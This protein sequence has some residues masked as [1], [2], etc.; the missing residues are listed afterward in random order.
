MLSKQ[1]LETAQTLHRI[2]LNMADRML[3]GQLRALAEH[4]ELRA[5]K[6]ARAD[7]ANAST[8]PSL[9]LSCPKSHS[10]A[11]LQAARAARL[12]E[13]TLEMIEDPAALPHVRAERKRRLT[14]WPA[15]FRVDWTYQLQESPCD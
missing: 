3:A 14:K 4:C 1:Y 11:Q 8:M 13:G 7:A 2:A 12:A 5:E 6:A 15:E 10:K 9:N